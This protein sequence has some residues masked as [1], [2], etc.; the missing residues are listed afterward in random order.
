MRRTDDVAIECP[1]LDDE[2]VARMLV[3]RLGA[4]CTI[5]GWP[6]RWHSTADVVAF[7]PKDHRSHPRYEETV[8]ELSWTCPSWPGS[9]WPDAG[10]VSLD[11]LGQLYWWTRTA[12]G[13]L[14][15]PERYLGRFDTL[16]EARIQLWDLLDARGYRLDWNGNPGQHPGGVMAFWSSN[17]REPLND[18]SWKKRSG[19]S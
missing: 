10:E 15:E 9:D 1:V 7:L 4:R 5:N 19:S 13:D 6:W 18:D 2:A 8:A 17:A 11:R 16:D 12:D 14:I 3:G